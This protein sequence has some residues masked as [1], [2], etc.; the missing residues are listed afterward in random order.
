M[1]DKKFSK[2]ELKKYIINYNKLQDDIYKASSVLGPIF[3]SPIFTG[4]E[5]IIHN[6]LVKMYGD[7]GTDLL[8]EYI[9]KQIDMGFDDLFDI[10]SSEEY[11]SARIRYTD[12]E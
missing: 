9:F 5:L 8:E 10:L 2:E 6:L 7:L 12:S 3:D 11:D 4:Y 1:K